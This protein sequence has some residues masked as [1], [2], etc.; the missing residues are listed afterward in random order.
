MTK[1]VTY[2]EI[3]TPAWGIT[4]PMGPDRTW[5]FAEPTEYLDRSIDAIPSIARVSYEAP[6]IS[7]G[8]DLGHRG[9]VTVAFRDHRHIMDGELFD[10]GTFWG[11]WRAR[12]GQKLRGRRLRLIRGA[13]G[14]PI[15]SME[16]R[17]FF[18]DTTDG[19][20]PGGV[21]TVVAKD[22]IKFLDHDRAQAP[23][24]SSGRLS[25]GIDDDDTGASLQ[26][27]G[28]GDAEYPASGHLCL[29]G[30]EIVAFTRSGDSIT[31]TR[32][33][34]GTPAMAHEAGD[35]AQL[36]L[37][38]DGNDPAD[39]IADLEESY[40]GIDPAN[41]PLTEWQT[42]TANNL[43]GILYARAITE[44]TPVNKLVA[45][46]I[47][48]AALAHWWD[49]RARL[50]RLRVLREIATDAELFDEDV[51][52]QG[53]L[54][55]KDQPGKRISQIWTHHGQ[56]NPAD[57]G[58]DEDN[59]RAALATVD[60][61]AET[62][63]G[64][65]SIRKITG[66]WVPTLIAASRLNQVQ[67]S[68]FT[69]PP[70]NFRFDLFHDATIVPGSG[71][72][73]RWRQNQDV[74]GNIVQEGAPIQVTRVSTAPGVIHVEAE[75]MLA[76]G[77]IV[78]RHTVL[79]TATGG[80][81]EWE[82]PDSFNPADNIV[83]CIGGGGG[84]DRGSGTS[85]S[86]G[87][88]GGGAAY[89]SVAN[90]NLTPSA[91]V[92]YRVGAGGLGFTASTSPTAGGDT[93][94]GAATFGGA[95]VG[96]RGGRQGLGRGDLFPGGGGPASTSIGDVR[97]NGGNGGNGGVERGGGGGAGAAAG[98]HGD[99]GNGGNGRTG[100][101]SDGSGGGG[102]GADGGGNGGNATGGAPETAG[103]GGSN[104]FG[105]GG[106]VAGSPHG[107]DGGGGAGNGSHDDVEAGNGSAE[108]LWTQ[109]IAPIFAAGA[110]G[111]PG[112]G[113]ENSNG[114]NGALYG[115]GGSGCGGRAS[116]AG[117]GAQG[118]IAISWTLA[119]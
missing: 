19:P 7:L 64:G 76:S 99:G 17:H 43:G 14:S 34:L 88:G 52:L 8:E 107:T 78:L 108:G 92:E 112:G 93:W 61:A 83:E 79:L 77:D 109:T 56:R 73:L 113:G 26:P 54:K 89:A 86:G 29:G 104:R 82:V 11:K 48:Q 57:R 53:S 23:R 30:K 116:T 117:N 63:Y 25:G 105:F 47:E 91:S 39:I 95:S 4:S 87:Q 96:A 75:E 51:I 119:P 110:G 70:R 114:R 1:I 81:L 9:S 46:M 22:L 50:L 41:I 68:R 37:Y 44:P 98:P 67:M 62:E 55:V 102:G 24:L 90:L 32:A 66:T 69:N 71:Y 31:I 94:F 58:D 106:G 118:I 72:R 3:D 28:I 59:Y 74:L 42:E 84:G 15:E 101:A 60:L 18:V 103:V 45:E 35:R 49:D 27:T 2:I 38:Y 40:A 100:N 5:R 10:G 21:Y 33:Q 65:P 36:V 85:P 16:T 6:I 97:F 13:A 20:T 12:Y 80:V 111:G 115:A